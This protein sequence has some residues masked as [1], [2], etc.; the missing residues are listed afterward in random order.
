MILLIPQLP[1]GRLWTAAFQEPQEPSFLPILVKVIGLILGMSLPFILSLAIDESTFRYLEHYELVAP[2]AEGPDPKRTSFQIMFKW[3]D[4]IIT[5][6][7]GD[8]AIFLSAGEKFTPHASQLSQALAFLAIILAAIFLALTPWVA[9]KIRPQDV[10]ATSP[11]RRSI[12]VWLRY[13]FVVGIPYLIAAI[14]IF[15]PENLEIPAFN[16]PTLNR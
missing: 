5:S 3:R 2:K 9:K 15:L 16:S 12:Q 10:Q 7:I 11:L 1:L 14:L 6:A 4:L 13:F 8:F